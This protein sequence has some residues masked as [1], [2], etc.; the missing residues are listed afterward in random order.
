MVTDVTSS[1]VYYLYAEYDE[2]SD[3]YYIASDDQKIS[4]MD[5]DYD[6]VYTR[7]P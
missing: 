4:S 7:Y 6:I 1:R 5:E 3:V 2:R